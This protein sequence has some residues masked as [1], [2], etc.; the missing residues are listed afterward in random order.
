MRRD[1]RLRRGWEIT[2]VRSTG[3][4]WSVGPVVLYVAPGPDPAGLPRSAFITGKRIGG[5]VERNLARRRLREAV[6]AALPQMA[7]GWDFVW[8]ARPSIQSS[9]FGRIN[10]AVQECLRRARLVQSGP[11]PSGPVEQ[12]PNEVDRAP[13]NPVL[14]NDP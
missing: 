9:D 3:R 6:R 1:Y 7:P 13:V 12:V 5:A 14:P 4:S 10:A 2:H 11:P 8:I